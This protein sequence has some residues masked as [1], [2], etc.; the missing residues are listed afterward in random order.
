MQYTLKDVTINIIHISYHN[1]LSLPLHAHSRAFAPS[2]PRLLFLFLSLSLLFY[3]F[4][5]LLGNLAPL[6]FSLSLHT[7]FPCTRSSFRFL[8]P[9]TVSSCCPLPSLSYLFFFFLSP[10]I[11]FFKNLNKKIKNSLL[12]MI[13]HTFPNFFN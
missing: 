9:S 13:S 5:Q 10:L 1:P 4:H 8:L 6:S 2:P 12:Y 3:S 11:S 7:T